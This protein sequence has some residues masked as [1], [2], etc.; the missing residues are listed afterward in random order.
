MKYRNTLFGIAAAAGLGL[1]SAAQAATVTF[2]LA[3]VD[4]TTQLALPN[5]GGVYQVPTGTQFDVQI[6]ATVNS[7]NVTDTNRTGTTMDNKP[8]GIQN[9][10]FNL[11]SSVAG[12]VAPK[13]DP[14]DVTPPPSWDPNFITPGD[15]GTLSPAS[16][17]NLIDKNAN[18]E[19]DVAGAGFSNTTLAL[20]SAGQLGNVQIGANGEA[21]L[22]SGSYIAGGGGDTILSTAFPQGDSSL[23]VFIDPTTGA[24]TDLAAVDA[25]AGVTPGTASIHV[26]GVPEPT[27]IGLAGFGLLGLLGARR[28]S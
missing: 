26:V 21:F 24:A 23:N 28:R 8:L 6:Y 17:M 20:S 25:S 16:P 22:F 10:A 2:R 4:T 1:A 15:L 9:L 7:P 5:I 19:L 18:V 3:L 13:A 12:H 27:T 14:T 11:V